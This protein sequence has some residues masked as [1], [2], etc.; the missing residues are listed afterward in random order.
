MD[1]IYNKVNEVFLDLSDLFGVVIL[2]D[3]MDALVQSRETSNGA[4]AAAAAQLDVTQK[5]LTTS[6]LPKLLKLR[7][8]A[9]TLFFMATNH[10]R[11]FDPAIKRAGRFD[12]LIPMGPPSLV[13]KKKGMEPSSDYWFDRNETAV[14]R[15]KISHSFISFVDDGETAKMLERFTFSEM[16]EFFDYLRRVHSMNNNLAES[17]EKI[18]KL[19]FG[20]E[21][22]QWASTRI[23]LCEGSA[24]LAEF[25]S[26]NKIASIH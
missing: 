12:L 8:Q 20:L 2:F 3:E 18:D 6:M 22:K 16:S 17:F 9:R 5:F 13:E 26:D 10:Q 7:E 15:E 24:Q 1:G 11:D 23:V 19:G 4:D 25:E 14:D 21:V